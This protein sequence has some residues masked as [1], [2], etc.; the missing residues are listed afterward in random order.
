MTSG[1]DN[2]LSAKIT[3]ENASVRVTNDLGASS[4]TDRVVFAANNA[5]TGST[6]FE[7][8]VNAAVT[9][10]GAFATSS[11]VQV[12]EGAKL[13]LEV[14]QVQGDEDANAVVMQKLD[15]KG[16]IVFANGSDLL[17]TGANESTVAEN[18]KLEGNADS[19][20]RLEKGAKLSVAELEQQTEFEGSVRLAEGTTLTLTGAGKTDTATAIDLSKV[21]GQGTIVLGDYAKHDT[22]GNFEGTTRVAG[23]YLVIEGAK[24]RATSGANLEMTSGTIESKGEHVFNSITL[25]GGLVNVGN[26]AAGADIASGALHGKDVHLKDVTIAL[27]TDMSQVKVD[28]SDILTIDNVEGKDT[29]LV[30]GDKVKADNVTVTG[31]KDAESKDS[32]LMQGKDEIGTIHYALATAR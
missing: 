23:G 17:L 4:T 12:D 31:L 6:V 30:K 3:G 25:T 16:E 27:A 24:A 11:L 5:Y 29:W 22:T 15:A 13:E 14:D 28:A 18:A 21:E 2:V 1:G 26:V 7:T 20:L 8:G 9:A 10:S 32:V 19:V